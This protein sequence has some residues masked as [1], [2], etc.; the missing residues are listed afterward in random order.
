MIKPTREEK[1]KMLAEIARLQAS[2][3]MPTLEQVCAAVLEARRKYSN[4]IRRARRERNEA[5]DRV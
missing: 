3:Q 1:A 4:K 2:G 5:K